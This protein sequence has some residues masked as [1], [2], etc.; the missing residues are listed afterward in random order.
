[1]SPMDY[2]HVKSIF[3]VTKQKKYHLTS[4]S[5]NSVEHSSIF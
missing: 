1:M 4:V 2:V 3:L 5:V